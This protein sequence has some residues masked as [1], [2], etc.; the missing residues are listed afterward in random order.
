MDRHGVSQL[1][2]DA[3]RMHL[4]IDAWNAEFGIADRLRF[5]EGRGGF[6]MIEIVT[7]LAT[8]TITPYGGQVL[9]YRPV[10]AAEDLLF[11][12]ERAYFT[13]GK[14]NKGGVPVCWPWFGPDPD[15]LGR[16]L[17]GFIRSRP[18]RVHA[19]EAMD[20]GAIRVRL[21]IADDDAT[22]ALWPFYFNLWADICV[23]ATL[24][25]TLTTRN[26]GDDPIRITQGLH[27][28]FSVGDASRATVTGLDG[29]RY[30]DKARGAQDRSVVQQ[31]RVGFEAEVNRIYEEVPARLAVEDPVLQ[32][33]I[34]ID[35]QG[36]RTCVVWN[37]W[38]EVAREMPDLDDADYRRFICVE[39]VNTA[40]EVVMIPPGRE[41][42]IGA[43]YRIEQ[44]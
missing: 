31:G 39:T 30:I 28:Y 13:A 18:W 5:V 3:L 37:P 6:V 12:S 38:V 32:R 21:G 24:S 34:L 4:D 1:F 23:G 43:E 35:T 20:D 44:L 15:G 22:R 41:A 36:S 16:E 8:A 25:V 26:A 19:C 29:C 27:T 10:E 7:A 2:I 42:R 11:V 33:R 9:H 17:H 40:S 14:E